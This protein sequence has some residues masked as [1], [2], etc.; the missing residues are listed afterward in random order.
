MKKQVNKSIKIVKLELINLIKVK[1]LVQ[2]VI[3][4]SIIKQEA[5]HVQNALKEH[6]TMKREKQPAKT[7]Y[8]VRLREVRNALSVFQENKTFTQK[9]KSV[10][11]VS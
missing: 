3:K 1:E 6:I 7:V 11:I 2:I 5:L 10:L 4:E 9:L 8:K